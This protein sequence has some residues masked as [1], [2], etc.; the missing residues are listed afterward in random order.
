MGDVVAALEDVAGGAVERE[1]VELA[2]G[3]ERGGRRKRQ[4]VKR[5]CLIAHLTCGEADR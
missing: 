3:R 2:L 1:E 5:H 4:Q